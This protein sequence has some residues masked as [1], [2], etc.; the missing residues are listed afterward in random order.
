MFDILQVLPRPQTIKIVDAG[1]MAPGDGVQEIYEPLLK[2]GLGMIHGFEPV[3][4][5]C[6]KLNAAASP[7]RTYL[8]YAVGDGTKGTFH[9]C[10]GRMMSSLY[11]PDLLLL[12][13][14]QNLAN[15]SMVV[16]RYP[17]QTHRLDDLPQLA[18]SDFLKLDVQGAELDVLRGAP[19]IL[20]DALVV[21]TE[22]EF[23][24]MYREQPLFAEVDEE[25][26]SHGFLLHKMTDYSSRALKPVV[27]NNHLNSRLSQWVWG[28]AVYVKSFMNFSTLLPAKL[29][30]LAVI[31]HAV[32]ES[33]DFAAL[34][35]SHYDRKSGTKLQEAYL[36][37]LLA[38]SA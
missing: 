9:L 24:P 22:V 32:Y 31:L 29:L 12:D 27:A 5:A 6:D 38:R 11:E 2:A 14:F 8:P 34:A 3:Q 37:R 20:A 4:D 7:D 10:N 35:L 36:A 17:I 33:F 15:F 23:V 25:L 1:A 30:K 21:H 13:K 28:D 26:R 16:E 19:H 18:D